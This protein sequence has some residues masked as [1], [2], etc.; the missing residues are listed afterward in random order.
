MDASGH[1]SRASGT[2]ALALLMLI[3]V[4]VVLE[5]AGAAKETIAQLLILG[6]LVLYAGIGLTSYTADPALYRVAGRGVSAVFAGIAGGAEWTSAA[7]VL[8]AAG[9][10]LL[11]S[12]DGRTL[13]I[14]MTGGYVVLAALLAPYLRSLEVYTVPDFLAAR[15]GWGA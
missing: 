14:G 10:L 7:I 12:Y 4:L 9:W 15:Y 1:L 3:I 13:L 2:S 5:R 8:G 6:A 11:G